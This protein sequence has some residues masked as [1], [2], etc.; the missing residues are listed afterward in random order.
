MWGMATL[1]PPRPAEADAYGLYAEPPPKV[2]AGL[3]LR[4]EDSGECL[5]LL[6]RSR[7]NDNTWG[8]PGG[9]A[10]P[11]D[12]ARARAEAARG[13]VREGH[14]LTR[15]VRPQAATCTPRRCARRW[16]SWARCRPCASP[17]AS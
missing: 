4:D 10:E 11:G 8:L 9:N 14:R 15:R 6:R 17:A 2:G 13:A 7:H 1:A 5:L 16:R 12:G 3:L